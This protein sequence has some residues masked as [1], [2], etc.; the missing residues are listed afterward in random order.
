MIDLQLRALTDRKADGRNDDFF[1]VAASEVTSYSPGGRAMNLYVP[2]LPGGELRVMPVARF[3]ARYGSSG[4]QRRSGRRPCRQ[5]RPWSA[6]AWQSG[7]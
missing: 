7:S 6:C 4:N 2:S 1:E 3:F 5:G